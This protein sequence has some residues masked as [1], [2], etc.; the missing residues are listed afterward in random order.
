MSESSQ[1]I[2]Y[3]AAGTGTSVSRQ[4]PVPNERVTLP[5]LQQMRGD[6]EPITMLAVYDATFAALA[7][8][9]GVDSLLVGDS[10]GMVVQ[11]HDST[12]PVTLEAMCYHVA[13]VARGVRSVGG[14]PLLVADMPFGSYGG[15][16]ESSF[17]HACELMQAGAQMVKL[18]GGGWTAPLVEMLVARGVPVCAHL[19]LTPQHVHALGGYR[20]Q[21]RSDEAAQ[22]LI[23]EAIELRD[24][25]AS[26][27]VLEMVP[28]DLAGEITQRLDGCPTIGIGAG[29]RTDGQVLVAHDMLG[30]GLRRLPR[31]VQ[32]F[33]AEAG[34]IPGAFSA[35]VEAVKAGRFPDEQRHAW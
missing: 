20:V 34:S 28:A 31:F 9:A 4:H 15:S 32:N 7:A 8:Q 24:A 26:L 30:A 1:I 17:A 29:A 25:G 23:R 19:G 3:G 11:G 33:L 6:G 14:R 2:P 5:R 12:V 10:V 13:A 16:L 27:L 21:G 22:R 18:E 35:Y